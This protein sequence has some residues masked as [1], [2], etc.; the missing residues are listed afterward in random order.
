MAYCIKSISCEGCR[1]QSIH[2]TGVPIRGFEEKSMDPIHGLD[3]GTYYFFRSQRIEWGLG[4]AAN[5]QPVMLVGRELGSYL[6][7]GAVALVVFIILCRRAWPRVP[8]TFVV[9]AV[10]AVGLAEGLKRL[11]RRPRPPDAELWLSGPS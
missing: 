2:D 7:L 1:C 11:V 4:R 9:M 6:A 3:W 5:I 8:L 10:L